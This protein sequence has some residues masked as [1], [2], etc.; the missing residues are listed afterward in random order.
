MT[1]DN[2]LREQFSRNPKIVRL[3]NKFPNPPNKDI[4]EGLNTAFEAMRK[5]RLKEPEIIES[6]HAVIV[7]IRHRVNLR[8]PT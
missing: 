6:D 3:I 8:D 1:T 5:L 2:Y 4:G 7:H